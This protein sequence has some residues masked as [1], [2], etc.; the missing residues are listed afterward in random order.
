MTVWLK[1]SQCARNQQHPGFSN[2][3]AE[4]AD[5]PC[6]V[7]AYALPGQLPLCCP[8]LLRLRGAPPVGFDPSGYWP[9]RRRHARPLPGGRLAVPPL[10]D[11]PLWSSCTYLGHISSLLSIGCSSW[12]VSP[13]S[14]R[15]KTSRNL[16][17]ASRRPNNTTLHQ[18]C[19]CRLVQVAPSCLSTRGRDGV[20]QQ[21]W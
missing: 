6:S 9:C 8:F 14:S 15:K 17:A 5:V 7:S 16:L 21:P 10:L 4:L 19:R 18:R 13:G 1:Y 2:L 11:L 12:P 3:V 20:P